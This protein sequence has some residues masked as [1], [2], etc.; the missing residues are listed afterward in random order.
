MSASE[1]PEK[2]ES[3]DMIIIAAMLI[4]GIIGSARFH[5]R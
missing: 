1:G 2:K 3:A 4:Y 5:M